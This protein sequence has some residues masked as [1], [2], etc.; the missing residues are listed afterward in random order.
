[1]S[2]GARLGAA[3][4]DRSARLLLD[5]VRIDSHSRREG[6]IAVRLARECE[7]LAPTRRRCS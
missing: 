7:A 2:R 5:L 3:D 4:R 1:M 6:A